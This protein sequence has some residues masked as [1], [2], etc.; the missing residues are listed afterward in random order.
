MDYTAYFFCFLTIYFFFKSIETDK[1]IYYIFSGISSFLSFFSRIFAIFP[2]L[3]IISFIFFFEKKKKF[4]KM[5]LVII[6]FLILFIPFIFTFYYVK[7]IEISKSI[8]KEAR[9]ITDVRYDLLMLFF[10]FYTYTIQTYGLGIIVFILAFFCLYNE[11]KI[12]KIT[13]VNLFFLLWLFFAYIIL[14]YFQNVRYISY[15]LM[16]L[17]FIVGYYFSKIKLKYI[18]LFFIAFVIIVA[19]NSYNEIKTYQKFIQT[20]KEISKYL[21]ESGGNV[22]LLSDDPIYSSVFIYYISTFDIN[23]T[24]TVYR[25]CF[26]YNFLNQSKDVLI[27]EMSANK[28]KIILI[29][30]NS[31]DYKII[32][33]IKEYVDFEKSFYAGN[34]TF[35]VY[36]VRLKDVTQKKCNYICVTGF[37]LCT[38]LS[39]PF[40]VK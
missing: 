11:I 39:S 32:E 7:G 25:P 21:F 26:F 20:E 8:I 38:D 33:N 35:D 22:G 14:T 2:L 9:E 1:K 40:D 6:P 3:S 12:K 18:I 15:L 36:S 4:K 19:W 13:R 5:L 31:K 23:K 27:N 28:I 17:I 34:F 16:P 37:Y 10:Y 24:V 29:T 30:R